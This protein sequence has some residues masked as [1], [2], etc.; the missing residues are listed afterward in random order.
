MS[1]FFK[2]KNNRDFVVDE[3]GN[4]H[5]VGY[6][7]SSLKKKK[8]NGLLVVLLA[9]FLLFS[10]YAILVYADVISSFEETVNEHKLSGMCKLIDSEGDY[11]REEYYDY[12]DEQ[13][14]KLDG[15]P[16]REE[17]YKIM[18]KKSFCAVGLCFI[19]EKNGYINVYDCGKKEYLR[20]LVEEYE[21][22]LKERV[23]FN[24][25]LSM[26][27]SSVDGY[28][29][30]SSVFNDGTPIV[31]NNFICSSTFYGEKIDLDCKNR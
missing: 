3:D 17:M 16:S 7:P 21:D 31:C 30:Y 29:N 22:Y 15:E 14:D 4:S 26:A 13:T 6:E 25:S 23:F 27:C 20:M 19:F 28:G 11:M 10:L 2:R 18:S 9:F 12:L 24:I 8:K 1:G 5:F